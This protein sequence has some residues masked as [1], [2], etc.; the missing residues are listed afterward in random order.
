MQN[1]TMIAPLTGGLGHP[2]V[3]P[4]FDCTS[5]GYKQEE[6]LLSG[7]AARFH[8]VHGTG[9]SPDGE[10]QI[11]KGEV[12]PYRT[13][14]VVRRP[15]D[16][17]HFNGIV[18]LLWSNVSAGFDNIR[19]HPLMY[20]DGYV[21]VAA[22]V[23]RVGI[24]GFSGPNPKGLLAFDPER[25][26]DL[27]IPTDDI[28][29]DIFSQ[30]GEAI[31][32]H[33]TGFLHPLGDLPVRQV[34]ARGA[35]QSAARLAAY[36][37]AIAPLGHPFSGFMLD[38]YFGTPS[39]IDTNSDER[40]GNLNDL[41]E[42][43]DGCCPA[44]T[45]RL[46]DIDVPVFIIN[47]ETETRSLAAVRQPDNERFRLWEAAGIAHA[48]GIKVSAAFT[49]T[50]LPPNNIDIQP[51]RDAAL[52]WMR[53]WIEEG[54]P[55]PVQPRIE[56]EPAS[57]GIP[58]RIVRDKLGIARG[59]VRLPEVAVPTAVHTGFNTP[60][61]A[62]LRGSSQPLTWEQLAALYDGPEDYLRRFSEAAEAAVE[63]GVLLPEGARTS[64]QRAREESPLN[65]THREQNA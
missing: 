47:S 44:G 55:P 33:R 62:F 5:V 27:S 21:I 46:R 61:W 56:V 29:F 8:F 58:P 28:S 36:I 20:E 35:S 49:A 6:Y 15:K 10:W 25:Y 39:A 51:F 4:P 65:H 57:G 43:I 48:G 7:D 13:R 23:Q 22:S 52:H 54:V 41:S 37:N 2:F 53:R 17:S 59:G 18:I 24:E 26:R 50:D 45:S 38:V 63:A 19:T 64:I 3:Q 60:D 42:L 16:D 12:L 1:R 30:I 31:G 11:R 32:P 9:P 40:P 14:I 34:I